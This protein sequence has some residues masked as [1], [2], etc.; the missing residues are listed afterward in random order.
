MGVSELAVI[1]ILTTNVAK[2][3]NHRSPCGDPA[4]VA[5]AAGLR[6]AEANNRRFSE[7]ARC[8]GIPTAQPSPRSA[9]LRGPRYLDHH[10]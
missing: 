2:Q 10:C 6:A 1:A 7:S 9:P 4:L 5:P 8:R 3:P